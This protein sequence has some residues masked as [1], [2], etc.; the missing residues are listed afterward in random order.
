VN[1]SRWHAIS[2]IFHAANACEPAARDAFVIDACQGDRALQ[3]E[4]QRLLAADRDAVSSIPGA[5]VSAAF[6]LPHGRT[7]GSYRIEGF[8]G[9]GGMG[10]VYRG[11]DTR[12]DRVVAIKIL[13]NHLR[14][15]LEFQQR[16]EREARAISQLTHPNICTLYDIGRD[17][18]I[19]FLVM[20]HVEGETIAA[21]LSGGPVAIEDALEIGI[22]T[23][24]ALEHAHRRNVVHRD[25]KPSNVM[26]TSTGVK[27]L[28]FGLAKLSLADAAAGTTSSDQGPNTTSG[29]LLGTL[30]YMSPEQIEGKAADARSDIWALGC[31][32]YELIAGQ[33]AFASDSSLIAAIVAHEPIPLAT[34]SPGAH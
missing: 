15:S 1:P 20:E 24:A 25:L 14:E 31:L 3:I 5:T 6:Q 33:P 19:D 28:D 27:L 17:D 7:L 30:P 18:G 11:R 21:R 10:H 13:P 29:V 23:A 8:I 2:R 26:L 32:L 34:L 22:Q 12:L 16:F 9:A 4:V